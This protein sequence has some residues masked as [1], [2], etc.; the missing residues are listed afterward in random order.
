M[1]IS[2]WALGISD[3]SMGI[4]DWG[5]MMGNNSLGDSWGRSLD[6]SVESVDWVSGVSDGSDGTVWLNKRVLSLDD[7]SVSGFG[8]SLG[9]SG[10]SVVNGVSVVVLWVRVVWLRLGHNSF[11]HWSSV[12][13]ISW[14]SVG[15]GSSVSHTANSQQDGD[16]KIKLI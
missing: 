11:G 12:G 8:G 7:I 13:S 14:S 10:Q 9:V 1:G 2:D 4:G 15:D 3:W 16:L 6:D 5:S